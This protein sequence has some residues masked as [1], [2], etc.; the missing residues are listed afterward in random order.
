[1]EEHGPAELAYRGNPLFPL[2]RALD[3]RT[4]PH[5]ENSQSIPPHNE[6]K[7]H[8]E[9]VLYI[10][11]IVSNNQYGQDYADYSLDDG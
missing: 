9:A 3:V 1:M 6:Q 2:K 7:E 10:V 5:P 11:A 8:K 4:G